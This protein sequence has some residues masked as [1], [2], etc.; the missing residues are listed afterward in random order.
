MR[1]RGSDVVV[2]WVGGWGREDADVFVFGGALTLV[3]R[4][5][6]R[7]MDGGDEERTGY[8]GDA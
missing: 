2:V 3:R 1:G 6:R 8:A 4:R 5:A 7:R